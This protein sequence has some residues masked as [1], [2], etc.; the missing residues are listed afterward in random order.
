MPSRNALTRPLISGS[1]SPQPSSGLTRRICCGPCAHAVHGNAMHA[2]PSNPM[3][4]RRFITAPKAHTASYRLKLAYWKA[5]RL[6]DV[7]F[8]SK[9][10][11]CV[12]TSH[13]RFTPNS[14][15][16]SGHR[17][18]FD[19]LVG[20]REKRWRNSNAEGLG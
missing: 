3:N 2:P 20:L 18:L 16:E 6:A 10:D 4:S 13:V 17:L 1:F 9:A 7:R 19:H 11:I 15:R 8:G 12:A 14:D 5:A